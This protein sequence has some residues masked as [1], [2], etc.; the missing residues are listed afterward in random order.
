MRIFTTSEPI[1]CLDLSLRTY[2]ALRR[3]GIDTIGD[4][5]NV[6]EMGEILQIRNIGEISYKEIEEKIRNFKF[7][8]YQKIKEEVTN[9]TSKTSDKTKV[10][11]ILKNILYFRNLI[12]E[13]INWQKETILKQIELGTLNNKARHA[14]ESIENLLLDTFDDKRKQVNLYSSIIG[15]INITEELAYLIH[16]I[17]E[18]DIKLFIQYYGF[19]HHTLEEIAIPLEITRERVR[20]ILTRVKQK[21]LTK[22][23]NVLVKIKDFTPGV[24]FVRIQTSLLLAEQLGSD[25]TFNQWSSLIKYSGLLG[26]CINNEE[27]QLDPIELFYSVCKCVSKS[28]LIAFS[29]PENLKFACELAASGKPDIPAKNLMIVRTLPKEIKKQ[30]KRHE[31]FTMAVNSRWISH[32]INYPTNET[33]DILTALGYVQ[34]QGDWFI[35]KKFNKRTTLEHTF[36]KM[37]KYCG[38]L[39]AENLC[40]GLRHRVSRTRYPVP[41]PDVMKVI[42]E[43]CGYTYDEGLWFWDGE[44]N[45]DLCRGEQI[46][47]NCLE[48]K[49]PVVHHSEL[50]EAFFESEL[51]F[52]SLHPT[53]NL[54]PLIE[55][56]DYA[57]Y[58]LRGLEVSHE[59]IERANNEGDKIPINLDIVYE[60]TGVIKIY[61]SLGILPIGTGVFLSGNL[62][63]LVGKWHGVVNGSKFGDIKVTENEIRGLLVPF[64]QLKCEVGDRVCMSFNTWDRTVSIEKV[65]NDEN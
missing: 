15:S 64:K 13:V 5:L 24:S 16:N 50:A 7:Q 37:N 25:I 30:I 56:F 19:T 40:S 61:G 39:T 63:K 10:E 35:S 3:A 26:N 1:D 46:I 20:Q 27:N 28:G 54:T 58:K 57:L 4:L 34:K 31:Y 8:N 9:E 6:E 42:L 60:K 2:N 41:P 49:G 14:G 38:P 65:H 43:K 52:A 23:R 47:F 21:I 48:K 53:L 62:P 11:I 32:E 22:A 33:I 51:S 12:K 55:R 44:I 17:S 45:Y 59:E 29:I 18:R 36:R